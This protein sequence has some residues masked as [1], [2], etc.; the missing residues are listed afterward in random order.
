MFYALSDTFAG[1][2]PKEYTSGFA[3]TSCVI[4][5]KSRKGRDAWLKSTKL[6]KARALSRKE[7]ISMTRWSDP[8]PLTPQTSYDRVKEVAIYATENEY[9]L[10]L[11][12]LLAGKTY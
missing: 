8:T 11:Y 6:L 7:A 12:H 4:A 1:N 5:F 10:P 2:D 3:N 9:D